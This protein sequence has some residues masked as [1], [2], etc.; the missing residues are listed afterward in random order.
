MAKKKKADAPKRKPVV[1]SEKNISFRPD[2]GLMWCLQQTTK[3]STEDILGFFFDFGREVLNEG[4]TN[5][6]GHSIRKDIRD[7]YPGTAIPFK[8]LVTG[9]NGYYWDDEGKSKY[10]GCIEVSFPDNA[11]YIDT[12]K[13][14][15]LI[16]EKELLGATETLPAFEAPQAR[17]P[18]MY[19]DLIEK[20]LKKKAKN[21]ETI[22]HSGHSRETGSTD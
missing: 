7:Y 15:E 22:S 9:S 1:V 4:I 12:D 5:M 21:D 20:V 2:N 17:T 3:Q 16:M 19:K 11:S 10:R 13:M 8:L 18:K 6:T 14:V